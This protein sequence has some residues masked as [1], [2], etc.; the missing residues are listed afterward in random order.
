VLSNSRVAAIAPPS[1]LTPATVQQV[2]AESKLKQQALS[3]M[4][5]A[6]R[7]LAEQRR[8]AESEAAANED[9]RR[10]IEVGLPEWAS[11]SQTGK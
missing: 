1:A 3:E 2:A 8:A 9:E 10:Q 5:A 11:Q 4:S 7:A 6:K